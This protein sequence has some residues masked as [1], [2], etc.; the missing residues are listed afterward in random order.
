MN[1]ILVR[2]VA[3][4]LFA[5]GCVPG[6]PSEAMPA[7]PASETPAP[8]NSNVHQPSQK[9]CWRGDLP[10]HPVSAPPAPTCVALSAD[11]ERVVSQDLTRA[12]QGFGAPIPVTVGFDCSPI[13][14]PPLTAMGIEVTGHLGFA[15]RAA[16][17]GV[18]RDGALVLRT[19]HTQDAGA[20]GANTPAN[21]V[22]RRRRVEASQASRSLDRTRAAL[23]A[24]IQKKP[25]TPT[26]D[27][28]TSEFSTLT[29]VRVSLEVYLNDA[30]GHHAERSYSG[31]MGSFRA[32]ERLPVALAWQALTEMAPGESAPQAVEDLDRE[33]LYAVW[34]QTSERTWFAERALLQMATIAGS[35]PLIPL[36]VPALDSDE[37]TVQALAVA[38]LASASGWDVRRDANGNERPLADVVNDYKREC[39][40]P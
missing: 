9:A 15:A 36:V 21:V 32:E 22:V 19:I 24:N 10:Q 34:K 4:A 23:A 13:A 35:P 5:Y 31:P 14:E 8:A 18:D 11:V 6:G 20:N 26:K 38:A 33:L 17:F 1:G 2:W 30:R 25:P 39:S 16:G 29:N 7:H 37:P 40:P 28:L 12:M 27:G 3:I